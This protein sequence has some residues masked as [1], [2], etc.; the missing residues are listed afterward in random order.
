MPQQTYTI[1]SVGGSIV[2]PPAG[3]D[4]GFLTAFRDLILGEVSKGKKF[5]LVVG[6]GATCRTYQNTARQMGEATNDDLD[7]IGIKTTHLNAELVKFIFKGYAPAEVVTNPTKKIRTAKPVII[8]AGWK[9]G[10][11]TDRDAVLLAKT[12][13]AKQVFNLSNID[14][15][16]DSDPRTN[17]MAQRIE[18]INWPAFRK[19]VGD[20]WSPGANVPFDPTAAKTAQQLKLKVGFVKGTDLGEVK[21]AITGEKFQ[22]SVIS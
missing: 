9:P 7:W 11:S 15:V 17:P 4:I 22:G 19:I 8:A 1:L 12:Y 3:F 5:I 6:G 18:T 14:Y 13:G 10:C 2:I 21:K 16:Y 20:K